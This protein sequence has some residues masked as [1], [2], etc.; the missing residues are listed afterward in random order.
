MPL[1]TPG[2]DLV[3]VPRF[4]LGAPLTLEGMPLFHKSL[5]YTPTSKPKP[6]NIQV[7]DSAA[8]I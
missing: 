8:A 5:K 1:G 4:R 6:I 3:N 2:V 7:V